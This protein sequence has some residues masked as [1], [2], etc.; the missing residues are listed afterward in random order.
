[1]GKEYSA[2]ETPVLEDGLMATGKM[3]EKE[4]E[5]I[6][7]RTRAH[8]LPFLLQYGFGRE[9]R[10]CSLGYLHLL[11]IAV[12]VGHVVQVVFER[13]APFPDLLELG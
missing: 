6:Y 7:N 10:L 8:P 1:M 2:Q 9:H 13:C 4:Y 5:T 11:S 12:F 3:T